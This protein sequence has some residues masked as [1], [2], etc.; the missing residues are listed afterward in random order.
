MRNL[1]K[2]LFSD[3]SGATAVEYG[4][5]L[6]MIFLAMIASVS[7]V[8]NVVTDKWNFVSDTSQEAVDKASI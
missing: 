4:I 6:A 2:K 3:S 1:I 8:G 7:Q 5:I